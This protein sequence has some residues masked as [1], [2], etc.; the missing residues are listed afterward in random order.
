MKLKVKQTGHSNQEETHS[1]TNT[2]FYQHLSNRNSLVI[3]VLVEVRGLSTGVGERRGKEEGGVG[4]ARAGGRAKVS[5]LKL[6]DLK[7]LPRL[8]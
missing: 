1:S 4:W 8:T 3:R 2:P 5:V 6:G 7:G